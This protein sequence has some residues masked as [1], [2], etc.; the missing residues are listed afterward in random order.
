M[1]EPGPPLREVSELLDACGI[2]YMVV[3][4]SASSHHGSPRTTQNIDLVVEIG[5]DSFERLIATLDRD[6]FYVPEQSA[7]DSV[8]D[9]SQFNLLDT[10]TGWKLDLIV[11]RDRR[12]S[13]EEFSRRAPAVMNGVHV[14]VPS[15]EDT[16]LAKLEWAKS[17]GSE[18]QI[19]GAAMVLAV[20]RDRIDHRYLDH[21]APELGVTELLER[22]RSLAEGPQP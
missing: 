9:R 8:R 11:R 20:S 12:F 1:T 4:S 5:L 7:R 6:R 3:G 15:P 21:W 22:A 10:R 17:G 14:Y 16:V 2:P 18:R 19:E 13:R